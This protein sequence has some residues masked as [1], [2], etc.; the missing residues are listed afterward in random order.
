MLLAILP[1]HPN[2]HPNKYMFIAS[3]SLYI[4]QIIIKRTKYYAVLLSA[5]ELPSSITTLSISSPL[6]MYGVLLCWV[7]LYIIMA[8]VRYEHVFVGLQFIVNCVCGF[9]AYGIASI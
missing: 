7:H 6:Y 5:V 1:F 9:R 2:P 8:T 4:L 3:T